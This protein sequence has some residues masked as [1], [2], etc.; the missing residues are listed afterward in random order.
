MKCILPLTILLLIFMLIC[1]SSNS[2]QIG[3]AGQADLNTKEYILEAENAIGEWVIGS[4]EN[5]IYW[6]AG[7]T[8]GSYAEGAYVTSEMDVGATSSLV[9]SPPAP[10]YYLIGVRIYTREDEER[11]KPTLTLFLQDEEGHVIP[12]ELEIQAKGHAWPLG[13]WNLP[14]VGLWNLPAGQITLTFQSYSR[15]FIFLDYFYLAPI[16]EARG[17]S[18][19]FLPVSPW[20]AEGDWI[21]GRPMDWAS[22]ATTTPG[23]AS[24]IE[25][26]VPVAGEYTIYVATWHDGAYEHLIDFQIGT[27]ESSPTAQLILRAGTYWQIE[28]LGS[29]S[30][31]E[32]EMSLRFTSNPQNP[33]DVPIAIAAMFIVP[34]GR[35]VT[36]LPFLRE[37]EKG[38]F[39]IDGLKEEWED[40]PVFLTDPEG[41]QSLNSDIKELKIVVEDGVLYIMVDFYSLAEHPSFL[42]EIDLD[43]NHEPEYVIEGGTETRW[44]I[45]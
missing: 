6:D 44:V 45:I 18:S 23:A 39:R 43:G 35:V 5:S 32:G 22:I 40:V 37:R 21:W 27:G 13:L 8:Q 1:S 36:E 9:F 24:W 20:P 34:E 31:P 19:V 38:R 29:F 3:S 14:V 17:S 12:N 2:P 33:P 15:R 41:D 7:F 10:G 25:F 26:Q 28:R 42:L 30:L 4:F 16:F 11:T